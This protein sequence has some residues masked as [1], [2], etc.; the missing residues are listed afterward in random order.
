MIHPTAGQP[1]PSI[2]SISYGW[3]PDDLGAD[4]F[5]DSEF[6][7]IRN[8]FEDAATHKITVLVSSGDSG[9][10]IEDPTQAQASYPA[11]DPWVRARVGTL[12]PASAAF[13]A[14]PF[15][16][17]SRPPQRSRLTPLR[18][19]LEWRQPMSRLTPSEES[20]RLTLSR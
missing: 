1:T 13:M 12:A 2:V 14:K 9:A 6:T 19:R 11:S 20:I 5:S 8:L 4:S 18:L 10:R 15:R 3:G 7:Q 16:T 17:A